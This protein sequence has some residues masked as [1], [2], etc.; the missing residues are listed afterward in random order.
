M[1][2]KNSLN[3]NIEIHKSGKNKEEINKQL[4]LNSNI[5]IHKLSL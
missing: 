1:Q 2:E 3:S 4:P 5:E